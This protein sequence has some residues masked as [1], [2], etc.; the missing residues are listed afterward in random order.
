MLEKH[1][2][3]HLP[4]CARLGNALLCPQCNKKLITQQD[5]L[6]HML[7]HIESKPNIR[8]EQCSYR[9]QKTYLSFTSLSVFSNEVF[10]I[11][12]NKEFYSRCPKTTIFA[13]KEIFYF[14]FF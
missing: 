1:I 12:C 8:C 5:M 11:P 9:Y 2:S 14:I 10:L 4:D 13:S 6:Q 7:T 3:R